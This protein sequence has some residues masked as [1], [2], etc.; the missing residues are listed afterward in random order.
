MKFSFSFWCWYVLALHELFEKLYLSQSA[1]VMS[2]YLRKVRDI[3][4][5]HF[6]TPCFVL[7]RSSWPYISRHV[8]AEDLLVATWWALKHTLACLLLS[9]TSDIDKERRMSLSSFCWRKFLCIDVCCFEWWLDVSMTEK[10]N[11]KSKK[12][13]CYTV[14]NLQVFA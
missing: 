8:T 4:I 7:N 10:C 12:M 3:A 5:T 9:N 14:L 11:Y 13:Y 2:V 6:P 1:V